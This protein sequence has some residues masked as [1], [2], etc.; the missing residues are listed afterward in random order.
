MSGRLIIT[1]KK[2]Y[3]PWNSKNV[4]RALRDERIQKEKEEK[5]AATARQERNQER[6]SWMKKQKYNHSNNN[7]GSQS[8]LLHGGRDE[9]LQEKYDGSTE[10]CHVN[11]FQEE[12][13][14]CLDDAAATSSTTEEMQRGLKRGGIM[15]VYLVGR[16]N[17]ER[18]DDLFYKRR[19]IL[20]KDVDDKLKQRQDP[21]AAYHTTEKMYKDKYESSE[22]V[23]LSSGVLSRSKNSSMRSRIDNG[24]EKIDS[25]AS[26]QGVK[27]EAVKDERKRGREEREESTRRMEELRQRRLKRE[28]LEKDREKGRL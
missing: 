18:I 21:M 26:N 9:N 27:R 25:F 5:K 17:E 19:D 4:E 14:R 28:V 24:R 12:E 11:L 3:T 20:R 8:V 10:L 15:P 16:G 1:N 7:N 23:K 22:A 6:I 2:S 13:K